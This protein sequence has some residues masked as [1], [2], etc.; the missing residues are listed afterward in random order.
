VVLLA[1][2]AALALAAAPAWA[3]RS[4]TKS[5]R[6]AIKRVVLKRC[7]P[8]PEPCVFRKARISTRNARYAW[9]SVTQEGLSGMLLKRPTTRS[10]RFKVIGIQ[11]GG[12]SECSY[13]RRRAPRTVLGD[14]DIVGLVDDTGATRNCG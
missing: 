7:G 5:E 11:G 4:A 12:V 1:A 13:W 14:L 2:G 10:R 8:V 9:A 6:A 3:D